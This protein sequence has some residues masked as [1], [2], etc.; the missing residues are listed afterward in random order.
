MSKAKKGIFPPGG[1]PFPKKPIVQY[2]LEGN[3]IDIYPSLVQA[4]ESTEINYASISKC[5]LGSQKK[6]GAFKWK[7]VKDIHPFILRL[8]KDVYYLSHLQTSQDC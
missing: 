4:S 6:A 2:S 7:Y 5:C 8:Q 1:T 3:I